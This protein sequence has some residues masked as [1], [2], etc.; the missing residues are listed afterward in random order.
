MADFEQL[1]FLFG[2]LSAIKTLY[3]F[4]KEIH[5]IIIFFSNGELFSA[6]RDII[7]IEID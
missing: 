5:A 2:R 3:A 1:I 6:H 7:F 4:L